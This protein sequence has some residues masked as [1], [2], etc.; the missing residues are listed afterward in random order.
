VRVE[1]E[2][3]RLQKK[4]RAWVKAENEHVLHF[5][6][7]HTGRIAGAQS[8]ERQPRVEELPLEKVKQQVCYFTLAQRDAALRR[9]LLRRQLRFLRAMRLAS[10]A[11]WPQF[12]Q[13]V[14]DDN[15]SMSRAE[16]Q[17]RCA[18]MRARNEMMPFMVA[19]NALMDVTVDGMQ[20]PVPEPLKRVPP[21]DELVKLQQEEAQLLVPELGKRQSTL[22]SWYLEDIYGKQDRPGSRQKGSR[23]RTGRPGSSAG[24]KRRTSVSSRPGSKG[25]SRP[26]SGKQSSMQSAMN[27]ATDAL[28]SVAE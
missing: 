12:V 10:Q 6:Q 4:D 11:L 28:G 27:A 16:V 3:S 20:V 8:I 1:Q 21:L 7:H 24:A 5:N 22:P 19:Q 26:T 15:V 25:G 2:I 9:V 17:N 18:S 13:L 14:R 23:R